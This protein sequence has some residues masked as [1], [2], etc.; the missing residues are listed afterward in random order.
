MTKLVAG[1]VVGWVTSPQQFVCVSYGE[2][3]KARKHNRAI[4]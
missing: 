2:F 3:V 4:Y 1:Y